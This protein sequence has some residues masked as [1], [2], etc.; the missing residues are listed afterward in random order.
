MTDPETMSFSAFATRLG[1]RP[2]Y[3][4]DLRKQ[5][6]LVLTDNGRRV[7][8]A[9]SLQLIADSRDP[10]KAG[11]AERH[12][13]ARGAAMAVPP[14]PEATA[15]SAAPASADTPDDAGDDDAKPSLLADRRNAALA[16]KEEALAR[17]AERDE[18]VELGQLLVAA[19]VIAELASAATL[20]RS[21][22]ES[23]AD[24][25]ASEVAAESDESRCKALII[26]HN[27]RLLAELE[28]QFGAIAKQPPG[29]GA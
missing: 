22:I 2:G 8:V 27:E 24:V 9:P 28:R 21:R 5:G 7:L 29:S 17:K 23:G 16:R 13:A 10:S 11:V 19:E 1:C 15:A 12:A 25:L 20:I 14:A 26:D 6:R 18:L 3:V 4:T